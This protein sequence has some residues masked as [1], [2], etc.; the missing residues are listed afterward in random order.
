MES[1]GSGSTGPSYI[2]VQTWWELLGHR[3]AGGGQEPRCRRTAKG[4]QQASSPAGRGGP[5]SADGRASSGPH[6][7]WNEAA[8]ARRS[9]HCNVPSPLS[10]GLLNLSR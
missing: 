6:R 1:D 7:A 5:E 3:A 10:R 2:G 8:P 9:P 4:V